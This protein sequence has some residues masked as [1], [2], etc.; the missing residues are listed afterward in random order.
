M[1]HW[2]E[3]LVSVYSLSEVSKYA[4]FIVGFPVVGLARKVIWEETGGEHRQHPIPKASAWVASRTRRVLECALAGLALLGL[5]PVL[6]LCWVLVRCTSRG[7]A[8]FRQKRMGRNGQEFELYKF[9]SMRCNID[10]E[11]PSHTVHND[12]RITPVGALLRRYKL[13]ELPQFWNVLKGD[14]SLVGPRPKLPHH[15]L[16]Y[17]PYRPGLTGHATLAFR[18]EERMLLEVP[19]HEIDHFY[20]AVVKPIKAELDVHY[21]EGATFLSDVNV[22]ART[23]VRCLNSNADAR[24]ELRNLLSRYAPGSMDRL[25]PPR[26]VAPISL[27]P[28]TFVPELTDELAGDL[29]DA[30]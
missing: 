16:L 30:A 1:S 3:Q 7:P 11:G 24:R 6:G 27:R 14:M 19:S 20:E 17:M 10:C 29:D 28:P 9:R 13:D 21:M 12:L 2:G 8:F 26:S 25:A 18:H 23:M 5:A 4:V 22:L 15:E